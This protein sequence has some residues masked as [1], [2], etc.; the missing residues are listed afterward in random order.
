M[1]DSFLPDDAECSH[2]QRPFLTADDRDLTVGRSPSGEPYPGQFVLIVVEMHE[3]GA[4]NGG[5]A[6][7]RGVIGLALEIEGADEIGGASTLQP[8]LDE[9]QE[10]RRVADY[11]AEEPVDRADLVGC[12][13]EGAR[14]PERDVGQPG[15]G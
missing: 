3:P 15:D 8:A 13:G 10:P 2:W 6:A 11:V 5:E 1:L 14:L 4:G 12:Q 7:G 9:A